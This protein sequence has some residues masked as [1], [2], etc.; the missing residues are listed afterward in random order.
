M[1][2]IK[3]LY[4]RKIGSHPNLSYRLFGAPSKA[5]FFPGLTIRDDS[6]AAKF[7]RELCFR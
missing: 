6:H 5:G 2:S 1:V 4:V 3:I 7:Y